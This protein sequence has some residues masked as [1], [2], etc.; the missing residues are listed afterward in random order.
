MCLVSFI[1][2]LPKYI[3]MHKFIHNYIH[4][5][6]YYFYVAFILECIVKPCTFANHFSCCSI[7]A[8]R[9]FG[10]VSRSKGI[11]VHSLISLITDRA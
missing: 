6:I 11:E 1:V 3:N 5:Y 4:M 10:I 8:Q 2:A 7:P 9:T